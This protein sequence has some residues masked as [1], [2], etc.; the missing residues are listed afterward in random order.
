[1]SDNVP[2]P[3]GK[4]KRA[5]L[6]KHL[7][8]L[9]VAL[10]REKSVRAKQGDA[11]HIGSSNANAKAAS[12]ESSSGHEREKGPSKQRNAINKV[13]VAAVQEPSAA[14]A[15]KRPASAPAINASANK[16]S[17]A[18]KPG[19]NSVVIASPISDPSPTTQD[20]KNEKQSSASKQ[21]TEEQMPRMTASNSRAP[22]VRF[23]ANGGERTEVDDDEPA[24]G[25]YYDLF[26]QTRRCEELCC[27]LGLTLKHIRAMK[28]KYDD[29]DMYCT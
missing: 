6:P 2:S 26:I 29:N 14:A 17:I 27:S 10:E 24:K 28:K 16:A 3:N 8:K 12:T 20:A 11:V 13:A 21:D 4:D 9:D 1:M 23:D 18:V 25:G 15:T 7:E 22:E 19:R 5:A